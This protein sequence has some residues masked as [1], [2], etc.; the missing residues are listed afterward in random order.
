MDVSRRADETVVGDGGERDQAGDV[1]FFSSSVL[2]SLSY[3]LV[4]ASFNLPCFLI[5]R[6]IHYLYLFSNPYI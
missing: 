5:I 3:G 6:I 1:L 2:L 4:P